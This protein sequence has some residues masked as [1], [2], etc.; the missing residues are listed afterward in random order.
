MKIRIREIDDVTEMALD[1]NV[2]QENV[3]LF[4]NRVDDLIDNGKVRIVLNLVSA[5]YISSLC[6]SVIVDAKNRLT[7]AGGDIKV[8]YVNRLIR[9]LFEIT[10]L[11]KK[12]E[13]FDTVEDAAKSFPQH[14]S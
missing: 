10:N 8:A 2:V 1:G 4:R 7:L 5:N 6:L 14:V 9:N 13:I 11:N 3:D 12:I